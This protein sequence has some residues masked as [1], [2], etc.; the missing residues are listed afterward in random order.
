MAGA[1]AGHAVAHCGQNGLARA[2]GWARGAARAGVD[3]ARGVAAGGDSGGGLAMG[4]TGRRGSLARQ[5]VAAVGAGGRDLAVL[6]VELGGVPV[7]LAV[8]RVDRAHAQRAGL[9]GLRR[10]TDLAG[11]A[12]PR[13][14]GARVPPGTN[15]MRTGQR[16]A[17]V[18]KG[19]SQVGC[20]AGKVHPTG[21]TSGSPRPDEA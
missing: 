10:G 21:R 17:T 13:A 14:R 18:R 16:R 12:P 15:P 8:G 6:R 11:L 20:P 9:S 3:T 7:P 2:A 19:R 5:G 4:A 1:G